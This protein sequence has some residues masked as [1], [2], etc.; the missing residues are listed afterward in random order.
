MLVNSILLVTSKSS[1]N[2]KLPDTTS[3]NVSSYQTQQN[4][5]AYIKEIWV[6]PVSKE[7]YVYMIAE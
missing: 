2:T 4:V 7:M 5:K 6:H 3:K 1:N